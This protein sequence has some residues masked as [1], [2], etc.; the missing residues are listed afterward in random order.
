MLFKNVI[1]CNIFLKQVVQH[2]RN[3][4]IGLQIKCQYFQFTAKNIKVLV[5]LTLK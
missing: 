1:P 5:T 2:T 3:K 4:E